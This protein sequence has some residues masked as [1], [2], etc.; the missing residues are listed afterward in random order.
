MNFVSIFPR[1]LDEHIKSYTFRAGGELYFVDELLF[2]NFLYQ[3]IVTNTT[4][5]RETL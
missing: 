2:G 5:N 3:D 4:H 1:H